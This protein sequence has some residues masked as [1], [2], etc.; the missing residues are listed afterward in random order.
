MTDD[1]FW[2]IIE[3]SRAALSAE[4]PDGNMARQA[5]AL[6]TIL[7]QLPS[8]AIVQFRDLFMAKME[9]AYTYDLW[10]A[11]YVIAQGCSDDGFHD[12]RSWLIS[13]GRKV[14]EAALSEPET[15]VGP[16]SDPAVE[17]VFFE[18]LPNIAAEA[19]QLKTGRPTPELIPSRPKAPKGDRWSSDAELVRR[20]PALWPK[21]RQRPKD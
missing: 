5:A 11:A 13:M 9:Q 19:Y 1:E 18:E 7:A 4:K 6:R 15:L 17:D 21:F 2:S 14:F 20:F 10:A 12:F 16:A 3:R 8:N